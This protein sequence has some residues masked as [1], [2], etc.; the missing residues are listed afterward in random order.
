MRAPAV[1]VQTNK[2][3]REDLERSWSVANVSFAIYVEA[4]FSRLNHAE[5]DA[6]N[7]KTA[8]LAFPRLPG[9]AANMPESTRIDRFWTSDSA[10]ER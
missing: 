9:H 7:G 1:L 3:D 8:Q 5:T 4:R 10:Q 2:R 6:F